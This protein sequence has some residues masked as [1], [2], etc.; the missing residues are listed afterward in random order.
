MSILDRV[1]LVAAVVAL[2]LL[3][4]VLKDEPP[5]YEKGTLTESAAHKEWVKKQKK[6][7]FL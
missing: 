6:E 7:S 2:C 4:V 3:S 5:K 1:K